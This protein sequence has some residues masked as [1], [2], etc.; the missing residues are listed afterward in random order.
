MLT[1]IFGI[2]AP[3]FAM[4][5][6]GYIWARRGL[7]FD[8]PTVSTLIT[9][10]G[11]PA[12]V[13]HSLTGL[14]PTLEQLGTLGLAAAT[15]IACCLLFGYV[16]LRV[17]GWDRRAFLP[18]LVQANSGNMG[19]PLVM[20]AFGETG[21]ALGSIV[22]FVNAFSQH[23]L[24]LG[25][26]S[27][28]FEIRALLRQPIIWSVL[29]SSAVLATDTV[30]P[31]WIAD[32]ARLLGGLLIP[33]MLIMLGTSLAR[34]TLANVPRALTL[35]LTRLGLGVGVAL[36]VIH[37]FALEGLVAGVLLLQAS[38]P[39]AVFNYV[40]AE[41]FGRRP[42]EV[43]ATVLVSTLLTMALL[44]LLVAFSLRIAGIAS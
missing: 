42:D 39:A 37:L 16:L 43:A 38:M 26:S 40:F 29:A 21:L 6:V 7:P 20:L 11:A 27:G 35:A 3:V 30:V 44:P 10:V 25:I 13:F 18:S 32:T 1:D 19:L 34:F 23:T 14:R 41:R 31:T 33:G 8:Q 24:G 12:L 15:T 4:T 22:F 9:N 5:A 2:V 36:L 28:T 17:L